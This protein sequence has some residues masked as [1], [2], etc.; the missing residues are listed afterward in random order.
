MFPYVIFVAPILF[1]SLLIFNILV[2]SRKEVRQ[3]AELSRV[4]TFLL[5]TLYISVFLHGFSVVDGGDSQD[6]LNSVMTISL[7][8]NLL[9]LSSYLS[10]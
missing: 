7:G 4:D 10:E 3:K 1:V 2:W 9:D 8:H 6:S 5:F